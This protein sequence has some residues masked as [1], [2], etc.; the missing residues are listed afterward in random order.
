VEGACPSQLSVPSPSARW[1]GGRA[2]CAELAVLRW[3]PQEKEIVAVDALAYTEAA[4]CVRRI[5][6]LMEAWPA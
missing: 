3:R 2:A 4:S 1:R 5:Q 6:A